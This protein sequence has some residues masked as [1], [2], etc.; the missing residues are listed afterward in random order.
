M[1]KNLRSSYISTLPVLL[2]PSGSL[3]L[4]YN[5]D[6]PAGGADFGVGVQA[7]DDFLCLGLD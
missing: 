6:T 1:V 7:V 3:P 4:G 2:E 5:V